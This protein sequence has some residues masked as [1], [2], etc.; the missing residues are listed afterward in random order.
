M[1]EAAFNGMKLESQAEEQ[2]WLF[3]P[4]LFGHYLPVIHSYL[5]GQQFTT[6][7]P[8]K[9]MKRCARRARTNHVEKESIEKEIINSF[10]F[11]AILCR[12][13]D[14]KR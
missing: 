1:Q 14:R 9:P 12:E 7:H 2:E 11:Q 13:Q 8:L 10:S 3:L 6:V 4:M 5:L